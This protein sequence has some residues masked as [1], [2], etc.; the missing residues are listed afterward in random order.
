MPEIWKELTGKLKATEKFERW[1][2]ATEKFDEAE[3]EMKESGHSPESP[4][5]LMALREGSLALQKQGKHWRLQE[6]KQ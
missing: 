5:Q 4:T 2:K 6:K 1:R 3:K